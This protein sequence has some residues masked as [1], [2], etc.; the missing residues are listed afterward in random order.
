[1]ICAVVDVEWLTNP[2][3]DIVQLGGIMID[4]DA[5]FREKD[6]FYRNIRR[7]HTPDNYEDLFELMFKNAA[8]GPE[9]DMSD[10]ARDFAEWIRSCEVIM[11]WG[12]QSKHNLEN[13]FA[14]HG[15]EKKEI[16]DFQEKLIDKERISFKKICR[17]NGIAITK[18]LHHSMN[19]CEYLVQVIKA[20]AEKD[21]TILYGEEINQDVVIARLCSKLGMKLRIK[22]G[23]YFVYTNI[24]SWYFNNDG[25][26]IVLH[27]ENFNKRNNGHSWANDYHIQDKK[28]PNAEEVIKYIYYHDKGRY[29]YF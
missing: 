21:P 29:K 28:F 18:A 24:S 27:H 12:E 11:V 15:I 6:V 22:F 8:T 20:E 7:I 1:M 5:D 4:T 26:K 13:I 3:R 17:R 9:V 16:I 14:E 23:F 10:A 2:E 25:K 19:D